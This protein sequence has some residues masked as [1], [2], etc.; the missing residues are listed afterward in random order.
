METSDESYEW[1]DGGFFLVHRWDARAGSA[2]FRGEPNTRATVHAS[3]GRLE[4]KWEWRNKGVW[5]P[6]CDRVAT[7]A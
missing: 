2:V 6:L 7:R 5:V 4:L 3:D 1:L